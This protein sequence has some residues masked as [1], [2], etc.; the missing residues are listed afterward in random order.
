MA[1]KIKKRSV[2]V[3]LASTITGSK[4][5][6]LHLDR[7]YVKPYSGLQSSF[8][9][10]DSLSYA[11]GSPKSIRGSFLGPDKPKDSKPERKYGFRSMTTNT[12]L[13]LALVV[14]MSC[15]IQPSSKS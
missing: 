14:A 8:P 9:T 3:G 4:D 6:T 10:K 1:T 11:E 13:I 12:K 5:K 2:F 15:L 7:Y